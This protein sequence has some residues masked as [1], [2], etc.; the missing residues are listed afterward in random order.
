[1]QRTMKFFRL[2]LPVAAVAFALV[3]TEKPAHAL[4]PVDLEA[5]AKVGVATN[6][7]DGDTPL[8]FGAGVRAGVGIFGFYGGLSFMHYFGS[9]TSVP[10][11]GDVST[12][13]NLFGVEL[14]YTISSLPVV[15][16]RPQLGV[17]DIVITGSGGG[18][19]T[20]D[21]HIYLEPGVTV[22][23]PL[24]LLYVGGDVNALI[25]P[26]VDQGTDTKTYTSLSIHG[27]VGVRF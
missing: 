4:G 23:V 9:S 21:G 26:G 1:M 22:L 6:P 8:G 5:G 27:Q 20:S 3:A 25:I 19:S 13:T 7:S 10:I 16:I 11:V 14:G 2:A 24:G 17:G 15:Q 12:T 18:Q